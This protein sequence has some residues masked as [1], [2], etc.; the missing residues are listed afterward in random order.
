MRRFDREPLCGLVD[1][2]AYLQPA[3][4]EL[5]SVDGTVSVIPYPDVKT[6]SF[7]RDFE[8]AAEPGKKVFT[9]RP[10]MG[11]LW[12][13]LRFR[14]G[15]EMEGILTNNLVLTDSHGFTITPPDPYSGQQR[16]FIPRMALVEMP[17][18]GVVGSPLTRKKA[19]AAPTARQ[20]G[21]FDQEG[22]SSDQ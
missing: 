15:D 20:Q 22:P 5:M 7:V 1:P 17:V 13:R 16:V 4:I 11:G 2:S 19:K 14:D 3:G 18:L 12:V 6:V 21:L 9:T 10:K 8:E